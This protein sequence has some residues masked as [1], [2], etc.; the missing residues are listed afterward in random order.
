MKGCQSLNISTFYPIEGLYIQ[1]VLE[2]EHKITIKLESQTK[3]CVCPKCKT[4][5]DHCHGTYKRKVQDLPILGKHVSLEITSR[6]YYCDNE[7]CDSTT[8]AESFNGFVNYY[9]R[10]TERLKDFICSIALETSCEG[11]AS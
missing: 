3:N 7:E 8:I 11:A 9:S 10:M 4:I 1:D 2:E 6:E 5:S